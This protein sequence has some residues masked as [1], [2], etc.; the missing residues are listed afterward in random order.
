MSTLL[1]PS[2]FAARPF[3][4]EEGL[5]A[6]MSSGQLR[7]PYLHVPTRGARTLDPPDDL[8]EWIR[9]FHTILPADA[10]FSHLTA[11]LVW[12]LPLPRRADSTPL[13][14][15]MRPSS[16]ARIRRRRCRGHKGLESRLVEDVDG[17]RI[18]SQLDSWC[19]LGELPGEVALR[20]VVAVGDS[21]AN[22]IGDRSLD[23]PAFVEVLAARVRPRGL[24]MLASALE[25]IR[26]GSRSPME[27]FTRVLLVRAGFP[28]PRINVALGDEDGEWLLTGDLVWD[29]QRVVL[30]YQGLHHASR[31]Q[32]SHDADRAGVAMD[33]GAVIIEAYAEDLFDAR[34]RRRLLLRVARALHLDPSTLTVT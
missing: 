9:T 5:A 12:D 30:E 2:G 3:S 34:R 26:Y 20:D 16:R 24:R 31:A 25:L 32:R 27:S 1:L 28:E 11:C 22:R 17:L 7:S 6:G 15:V 10:A 8:M 21:I 4:R 18:V 29:D 19:D 33:H 13:V 23:H 14:D